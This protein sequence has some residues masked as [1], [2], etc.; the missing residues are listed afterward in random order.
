MVSFAM[1]AWAA[2]F[3]LL[4]VW[5]CDFR[6]QAQ[7][8]AGPRRSASRGS[9]VDTP[10]SSSRRKPAWVLDA[11]IRL[12][13]ICPRAS[14]RMVAAL[15]N[16]RH[17]PRM[18]VS[19]SWVD[20]QL[21]AH[22]H[23][24]IEMRRD[25]RRRQPWA[26]AINA[27]WALDLT[28]IHGQPVL[29]IVDHGSRRLLRLAALPRKCTFTLLGHLCLTIARFGLPGAVRTDNEAMFT[30]RL[31]RRVLGWLRVRRQRSAPGRPWQNGRIERLFGTVKP[32]LRSLV[33]ADA[34]T[35]QL[36]RTLDL[37]TLFYNEQRPHLA[38]DG[39]TPMHAWLGMTW[40]D[41]ERM[42]GTLNTKTKSEPLRC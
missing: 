15:F 17:R 39:L 25:L 19:K 30:S 28:M 38:L 12:K 37:A 1:A 23:R 10:G 21:R 18:T 24:V 31:W 8:Y 41:V 6:R 3:V 14:V 29:G 4:A 20:E 33:A 7:P 32:W 5:V 16:L 2:M 36:Q 27:V 11:V 13:A 9:H 34:G 26:V 42:N 40:S 35:W 22:A